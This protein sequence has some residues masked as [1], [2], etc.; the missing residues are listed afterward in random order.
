MRSSSSAISWEIPIFSKDKAAE[1]IR[2]SLRNEECP[3]TFRLPGYYEKMI[4]LFAFV[5][6]QDDY[7]RSI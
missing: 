2:K 1:H 6:F 5:Y 7:I 3:E 4:D